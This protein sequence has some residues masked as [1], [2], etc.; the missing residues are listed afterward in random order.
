MIDSLFIKLSEKR[1]ANIYDVIEHI[2]YVVKLVGV[3]FVGLGSDF[4]G[5]QELPDG[6]EGANKVF[7][8][9]EILIKKGYTEEDTKII[10]GENFLKLFQCITKNS[11]S[12][13]L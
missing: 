3:D 11:C 1:K 9:K 6:L 12:S 8:I 4:D 10:M 13:L 2:H 7:R 5:C